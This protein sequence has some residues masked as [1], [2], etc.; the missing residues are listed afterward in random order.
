MGIWGG[1]S[2]ATATNP[3]ASDIYNTADGTSGSPVVGNQEPEV[4]P[5]FNPFSSRI[6][7]PNASAVGSGWSVATS[8]PNSTADETSMNNNTNN[9]N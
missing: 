9:N 7:S 1:N 4:M 6:W 2:A 5:T 8:D 3:L